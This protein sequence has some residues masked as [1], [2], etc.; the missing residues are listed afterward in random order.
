MTNFWFLIALAAVGGIAVT[1]QGQFMGTMTRDLGTLESVFITYASGGL[2][3]SL[4]L[5]VMG[6]GE[7]RAWRAVPPYALTAGLLGLLI[8]GTIGYVTSHL[9]LVSTFTVI[10]AAQFLLAALFDHFGWLNADL[11][12]ITLSRAIGMIVLLVGVWLILR[13]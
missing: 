10:V 12:P 4:I 6:G 8:V 13:K 7:L 3:I 11:H 5:L 9:G 1:L 2:V